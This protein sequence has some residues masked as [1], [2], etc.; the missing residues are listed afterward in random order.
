MNLAIKTSVLISFCM[1]ILAGCS[2]QDIRDYS[3]ANTCDQLE[4]RIANEFQKA[5]YCETDNDCL[6]FDIAASCSCYNLGNKN[7]DLS[8]VEDLIQQTYTKCPICDIDC[9]ITP[10]NNEIVCR[11]SK[12]VEK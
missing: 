2:L 3:T 4:R 10:E 7:A 12:C 9:P 6:V 5:N 8:A 1:V 11:Q